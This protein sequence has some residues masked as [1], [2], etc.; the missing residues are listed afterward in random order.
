DLHQMQ[1]SPG[2]HPRH[3]QGAK[4]NRE[5]LDP[6]ADLMQLFWRSDEVFPPTEA[7][8]DGVP[9][10]ELPGA[11]LDDLANG[12]ALQWL[13]YL[14]GRHIRFPAVHATAHVW[15]HRQ[16]AIAH[17]H[18]PVLGWCQFDLRQSKVSSS[19]NPARAGGQADFAARSFRHKT[20]CFEF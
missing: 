7:G 6:A 9:R 2:G 1:P 16:E 17:E 11:R 18:L 5:R 10:L 8:S 4:V 14:K 19:W 20:M 3:T 13:A 15:V 12:A